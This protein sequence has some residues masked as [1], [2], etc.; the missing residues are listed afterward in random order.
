MRPNEHSQSSNAHLSDN[1]IN[2]R[3]ENAYI[4][5][6]TGKRKRKKPVRFLLGLVVLIKG[7]GFYLFILLMV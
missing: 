2:A 7:D 5:E 3:K 4:R 1:M 6:D